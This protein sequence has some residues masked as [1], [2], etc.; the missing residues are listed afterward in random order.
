MTKFEI[1]GRIAAAFLGIA[2]L[3]ALAAD[4][5]GDG[6]QDL[7]WRNH[8]GNAVVWQMNGLAVASRFTVSPARDSGAAIVGGGN[9]FGSSPGAI[10]WVDSSNQLSLWRVGNGVVQQ[11]CAVAVDPGWSFLGIGDVDGNGIDDVAWRL[12]DGSVNVYLMNGCVAPQ[13]ITLAATANAAWT[14]LGIGDVDTKS[15]GALFWR[16]SSGAVILWRVHNGSG[17]LTSTLAA[18]TYASWTVAAVADFDGDGRTDIAWRDPGGTQAALWLMN[19]TGYTAAAIVPAHGAVF[20]HP[21]TIFAAGFD[22]AAAAAPPLTSDWTVLGAAD[23]NGD[24]RSDIVLADAQGNAAVWQMQG[25]TVQ[26]TGLV[27]PIA[28][29]PYTNLSGWRMAIDRPAVTKTANQVSITW[30]AVSGSPRYTVYAS[31]SNDPAITGIGLAATGTSLTFA[32]NASGYADKRYFAVSA[33][34]LGVQLPPSPEAY[35]VE[36]A[37][38]VLPL[39]G[40]MAIAD[41]N[42]DGC[43]DLLDAL[44]NCHGNFTLLDENQ[45]G[46]AALRANGRAYR[47]VRYADLDGDGIDDLISNV[48]AADDDAS[49]D[50]LFFRGLGNGHFVEDAAFT[51]LHIRGFGETI[52][53]ADFNNDGYLDVYL[54]QYSMDS[55]DDHS[56]LLQND[57]AGHFVDVSDLTGVASDPDANL[58]LRAV[59]SNCR[60]EA[61]Q[62]LDLDGDGKIDLYVGNHLFLNQGADAN[63]VPHFI[64]AG[65]RIRPSNFN[66][67]TSGYYNCVVTAPS[68]AGLPLFHDEGAKFID[69]DNS[70]QLALVLNSGAST[71]VGSLGIGVFKFDGLGNFVDVSNVVPHFFMLSVW[72]LAAADVDGDG[73]SDL[74]LPGG[75]SPDFVPT[76]DNNNCNEPQNPRIPPHLLVNRG[77]H[78]VP[79]DFYMDSSAPADVPWTDLA[80]VADVDR[81]GPVG[82][83]LRSNSLTTF[84]N[85][86]RSDD[87]IVV[88]VVGGNDEENQAGRIVRVSPALQPNVTMTQVVDGGSGYLANGQYDLTFAAPYPGPYTVTVRFATGSYIAKVQPGSHVTMRANGTYSVQ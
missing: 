78:F 79:H 62:A 74:V 9:F 43:I 48:Y 69:L 60:V 23:V 84:Q 45:I 24:G 35:I 50:V 20:S 86:A 64:D 81:S 17:V 38:K 6:K 61:A 46:L 4:F 33:G 15:T 1:W 12:P 75:C 76:P 31:A 30:K 85:L 22:S 36:F 83:V 53:I 16:D 28:D 40:A 27:P 68:P 66:P 18:G 34:Y 3:P 54:P 72:G 82:L 14:F 55:P 39:W 57:G 77:G 49:S 29:M 67:V 32:R 2:A 80:A 21:N 37:P 25:A 5:N 19:G 58:A 70:G 65:P 8:T 10:L 63:G 87:A 44:G 88:R 26:T 52:V 59:P 42:D 56:W 73:L 13:T 41:I 11:S 7:L 71:E 51:N 47:D